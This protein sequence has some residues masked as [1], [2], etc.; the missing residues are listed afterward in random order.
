MEKCERSIKKRNNKCQIMGLIGKGTFGSIVKLW[1]PDNKKHIAAKIQLVERKSI[2]DREFE[3]MKFFE[4]LTKERHSPC[5][6]SPIR[7]VRVDSI[8]QNLSRASG[9][10]SCVPKEKISTQIYQ[11]I[12]MDLISGCNIKEFMRAHGILSVHIPLEEIKGIVFQLL[13]TINC[14]QNIN[15]FKHRDIKAD[16]V[17]L[18]VTSS[19]NTFISYNLKNKWVTTSKVPIL[20]DFNLSETNNVISDKSWRCGTL[21]YMPPNKMYMVERKEGTKEENYHDPWSIGILITS[22]LLCGRNV[23][24]DNSNESLV[25]KGQIFEPKFAE[26]IFQLPLL[27]EKQ[28]K[29]L[30]YNHM[31][32]WVFIKHAIIMSLFQESLGN[33]PF[34][35][36]KHKRKKCCNLLINSNLMIIVKAKWTEV[37]RLVK[38]E[39]IV[40]NCV[41][42]IGKEIGGDAVDLIS[43]LLCWCPEERL[44]CR[45][46]FNHTFFD[47]LKH[48]KT[49]GKKWIEYIKNT[50]N[51]CGIQTNQ[52]CSRCK[53]V[54]YCSKICFK[55]DWLTH[56]KNCYDLK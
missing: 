24:F 13:W 21:S 19:T 29:S 6:L 12:E 1:D 43:H 50:C 23:P 16:N 3:I 34:P 45:S 52:R 18:T 49:S 28:I 17:M 15:D 2:I 32:K 8:G 30:F 35:T 25:V 55:S 41:S 33:G 39:A 51:V 40:S 9:V 42:L 36:D 14:A 56:C 54:H 53:Q 44:D 11:I 27:K 7:C 4:Q 10:N 20:I 5:T 31:G 46:A 26:T 48:T 22:L 38:G 37:K 47:S